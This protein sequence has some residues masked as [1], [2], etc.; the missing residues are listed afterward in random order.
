MN[1]KPSLDGWHQ[2]SSQL[3]LCLLPVAMPPAPCTPLG[4]QWEL[5]AAEP[6]SPWSCIPG[7][8]TAPTQSQS[9]GQV[10]LSDR[11][12]KKVINWLK[13][14]K[15]PVAILMGKLPT[16]CRFYKED[17]WVTR[18]RDVNEAKW[19]PGALPPPRR[20]NTEEEKPGQLTLYMFQV[21]LD[22][23]TKKCTVWKLRLCF[24]WHIFE[25]CSPKQP[26]SELQGSVQK[27][28][29][30]EPGHIEF[31]L[32]KI[33]SWTSKDYAKHRIQTSQVSDF[34]TFMCIGRQSLGSLKAS[35]WCAS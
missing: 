26:L 25:D 2:H 29:K 11:F 19:I 34:S 33:C 32:K 12:R 31:L 6:W 9:S 1:F 5:L 3:L 4:P 21:T 24:I 13:K 22:M 28:I 20:L 7:S 15:I 17:W 18:R 14:N 23:S 27:E 8:N 10:Y 35:L 30:E 16:R